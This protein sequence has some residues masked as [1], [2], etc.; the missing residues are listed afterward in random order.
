M[1][2]DKNNFA[3]DRI[4]TFNQLAT[5]NLRVLNAVVPWPYKIIILDKA[6]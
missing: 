6:S 1:I 2:C 4:Y 5:T 3:T